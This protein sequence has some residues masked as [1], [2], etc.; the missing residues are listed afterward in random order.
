MATGRRVQAARPVAGV[1]GCANPVP[2]C[3]LIVTY[4]FVRNHRY[5]AALDDPG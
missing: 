2:A 4:V 1:P 5:N 3:V